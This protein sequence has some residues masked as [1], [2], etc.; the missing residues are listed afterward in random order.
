LLALRQ[1]LPQI[2]FRGGQVGLGLLPRVAN[3]RD[4]FLNLVCRG[5]RF[6]KGGCQFGQRRSDRIVA[7]AQAGETASRWTVGSGITGS[8]ARRICRP[9]A[10]VRPARAATG[11]TSSKSAARAKVG[12]IIVART[13]ASKSTTRAATA[14]S[15]AGARVGKTIAA[16]AAAAKSAPGAAAPKSTSGAASA[17][18]ATRAA[19]AKSAAGARVGKTIVAW[20]TRAKSPARAAASKSTTWTA[21]PAAHAGKARVALRASQGI[22]CRLAR[23]DH[24]LKDRRDDFPFF[25]RGMKLALDAFQAGAS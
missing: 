23:G 4:F 1:H 22:I 13:A 2:L 6:G 15:A 19:A 24:R 25:I 20:T 3:R 16:G 18:S 9:C 7:S 8:C 11:T 12:K 5:I 17:K 14:K 10:A 21:A